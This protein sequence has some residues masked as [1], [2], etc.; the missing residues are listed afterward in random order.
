MERFKT[1]QICLFKVSFCAMERLKTYQIGLYGPKVGS[2]E[3]MKSPKG[4]FVA[5]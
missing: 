3:D 4:D 1:S 2:G 5:V